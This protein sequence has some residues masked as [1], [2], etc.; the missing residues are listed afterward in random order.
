MKK[1]EVRILRAKE[2]G[3]NGSGGVEKKNKAKHGLVVSMPERP[4]EI[5]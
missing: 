5:H 2:I 4:V 1:E 3:K